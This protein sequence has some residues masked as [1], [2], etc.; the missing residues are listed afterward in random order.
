MVTGDRVE[1]RNEYGGVSV[2]C[3]DDSFARVHAAVRHEVGGDTCADARF[4]SI[5]RVSCEGKAPR[6]TWW[7]LANVVVCVTVSGAI[8]VFGVIGLYKWLFP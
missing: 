2:V 4:I 7:L 3:D 5:R 1:V 6:F 8:Q